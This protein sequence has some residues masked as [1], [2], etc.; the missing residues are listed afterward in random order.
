MGWCGLVP[1]GGAARTGR[2]CW[3]VR[4]GLRASRSPFAE[5]RECVCSR[6]GVVVPQPLI[7]PPHRAC[8]RACTAEEA[9]KLGNEEFVKE[10]WRAAL[11]QFSRA[12]PR[13]SLNRE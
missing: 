2:G 12:V 9:F 1:F 6:A 3:V 13:P 7:L 10:N 4:C 8:V 11:E 5:E